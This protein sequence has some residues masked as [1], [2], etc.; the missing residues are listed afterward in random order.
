MMAKNDLGGLILSQ[1]EAHL[2]CSGIEIFFQLILS[3]SPYSKE[4]I[5]PKLVTCLDLVHM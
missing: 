5:K 2:E 1:V 4:T 3:C